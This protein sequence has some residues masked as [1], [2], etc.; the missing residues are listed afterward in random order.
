MGRDGLEAEPLLRLARASAQLLAWFERHGGPPGDE[1]HRACAHLV[2]HAAT[3]DES[4]AQAARSSLQALLAEELPA[5]L[6]ARAALGEACLLANEVLGDRLYLE[7]A[8]SLCEGITQGTRLEVG[9]ALCFSAL[10][11]RMLPVHHA[12]L[13]AA[14]LLA[15]TGQRVG[16]AGF[17]ELA[18]RAAVFALAHQRGDGSWLHGE[19]RPLRWADGFH[20][21][22]RVSSL[23]AL[24]PCGLHPGLPAALARA[25]R[26]LVGLHF[27]EQ[28]RPRLAMRVEEPAECDLLAAAEA[29]AALARAA[30]LEPLAA[31][32]AAGRAAA[33]ADWASR[34]LQAWSLWRDP[35]S[36][37]GPGR[38]LEGLMRVQALGSGAW[39]APRWGAAPQAGRLQGRGRPPAPGWSVAWPPAAVPLGSLH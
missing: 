7:A 8:H 2:G 10:P 16:E 28:D 1:V 27:D 25:L 4:H 29:M 33:L 15:G 14:A 5:A 23:L 37:H 30:A 35:P 3:D 21:A 24:V 17:V 32:S 26:H 11:G 34:H 39:A 18:R 38:L 22:A 9:E 20:A 12:N 13:Q 36:V 19:V 6:G 31:R